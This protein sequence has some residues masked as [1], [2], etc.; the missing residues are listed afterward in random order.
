MLDGLTF[1]PVDDVSTVMVYFKSHARWVRTT[2]QLLRC[3][4]CY[5]LIPPGPDST[6]TRCCC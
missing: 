5:R 3:Y 4:V 1:L 2:C 6:S